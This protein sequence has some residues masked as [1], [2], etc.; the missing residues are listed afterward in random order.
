[1][2]HG[3][4]PALLIFASVILAACSRTPGYVIPPDDMA[5]LLADLH[6]AEGVTELNYSEYAG[7]SARKALKQAVLEKHAVSQQ[8]L[9]TSLVWYGHNLALYRDVYAQTEQLLNRRLE[10]SIAVTGAG[11]QVATAG[12]SVDIWSRSKMLIVSNRSPHHNYTFSVKANINN[13]PGDSYTWYG[14]FFNSQRGGNMIVVARYADGSIETL[15]NSFGGDGLQSVVFVTD[16]TRVLTDIY[17]LLTLHTPF[18]G[19]MYVDSI[20]FVRKRLDPCIYGQ[21]YRQRLYTTPFVKED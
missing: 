7:D 11:T 6:T 10:N 14:K 18:E 20:R 8:Q 21:R 19:D 4:I 2:R 12:D 15:D 3:L 13:L 5:E 9:D 16:S 17:G 1:M